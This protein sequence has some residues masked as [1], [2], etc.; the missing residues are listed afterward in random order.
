M[1]SRLPLKA[2]VEDIEC[3]FS[4]GLDCQIQAIFTG[5]DSPVGALGSTD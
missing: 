1:G 2:D 4:A 5:F 3:P